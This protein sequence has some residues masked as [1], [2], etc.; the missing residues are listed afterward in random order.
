MKKAVLFLL[1]SLLLLFVGN[2]LFGSVSI[3]AAEVWTIITGGEAEKESWRFIILESRLPQAITAILCGASLAVSGLLLQTSFRNPLAGPSILGITNGASLGVAIVML[4]AGGTV[5]G[6]GGNIAVVLGALIGSLSVI[7][8]LLFLASVIH[9]NIMLLIVGIMVSFLVSSIVS[10]TY[11]FANAD[12]VHAYVMW[13]MGSFSDVTTEQ[14]P[15]FGSVSL[16]ALLLAVTLVK[17]LNA[18]LLGDDY[19]HNL[20]INIHRTRWMILLSTGLLTAIATAYCGP[21]AFLGLATPHIARLMLNTSNHLQVLPV[22][23]LTG[24][25]MALA[26]NLICIIPPVMI[27]LNAVTPIFGVPVIL[28][29]I[30]RRAE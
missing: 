30:F 28:Y 6:T 5:A 14:L 21:V 12:N 16:L 11:I 20:G 8:L 23:I 1:C 29:I 19:A 24:A 10:L 22:T 26:C 18:L 27:P 25:A 13:G 9:S 15:W 17:P 3:P 7:V 4:I 2:L